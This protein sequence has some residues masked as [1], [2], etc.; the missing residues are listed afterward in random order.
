MSGT[1]A[2]HVLD[3]HERTMTRLTTSVRPSGSWGVVLFVCI[4]SESGAPQDL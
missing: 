2:A 4:L 3:E 1:C